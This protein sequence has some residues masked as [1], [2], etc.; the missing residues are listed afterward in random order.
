[1]NELE[2]LRIKIGHYTNKDSITGATVI[3]PDNGAVIYD[4]KNS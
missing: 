1:M 2:K 3:I 4:R